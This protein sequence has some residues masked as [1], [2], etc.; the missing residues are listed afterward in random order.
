VTYRIEYIDR[1]QASGD[2][3]RKI[4]KD[5]VLIASYWH[6]FRGDE[7]EVTFIHSGIKVEPS[8]R[9]VE[10]I[11]GGGSEPLELSEIGVEFIES[12]L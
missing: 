8:F 11:K 2:Y 6:D 3:H 1:E 9:M 4:Y 10:F 12:Y 7:Y 5:N